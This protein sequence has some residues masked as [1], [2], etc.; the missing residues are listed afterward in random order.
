M[1]LTTI[2]AIIQILLL[3][4]TACLIP[5]LNMWF[6]NKLNAKITELDTRYSSKESQ[7]NVED[8]IDNLSRQFED[9]NKWL[10]E[11]WSK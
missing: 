3:I 6:E 9:L 4:I 8:K 10:R 2:L 1:Q 11:N 7:K 5:V